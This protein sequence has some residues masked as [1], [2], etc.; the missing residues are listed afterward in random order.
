MPKVQKANQPVPTTYGPGLQILK[1]PV[2]ETVVRSGVVV[3]KEE[4]ERKRVER[5]RRYEEA[6]GRIFGSEGGSSG[7]TTPERRGMGDAKSREKDEGKVMPVRAPKGPGEG[8]GFVSA[9]G[10]RKEG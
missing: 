9:R 4:E 3:S 2:E 7:S 5:E 1:R 10:K 8:R 6:R